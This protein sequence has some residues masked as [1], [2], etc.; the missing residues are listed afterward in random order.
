MA[1][2]L[3]SIQLTPAINICVLCGNQPKY[4]ELELMSQ[5]FWQNELDILLSAETSHPRNFPPNV[6]LDA[7]ILG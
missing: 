4:N 7:S 5:Q 1:Y 2:R 3:V 6:E